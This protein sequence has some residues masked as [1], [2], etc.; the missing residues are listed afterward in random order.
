MTK[1]ID[2]HTHSI[3]SDGSF[4]PGQIAIKAQEK[5]LKGIV[6]TDHNI[7]DGFQEMQ[8]SCRR[9]RLK[10]MSGIE[11]TSLLDD[12]NMHILLYNIE[13]LINDSDFYKILHRLWLYDNLKT[14]AVIKEFDKA[15]LMSTS[16]EEIRSY[17]NLPGPFVHRTKVA[18]YKARI[19]D[20]TYEQVKREAKTLGIWNPKGKSELLAN[21]INLLQLAMKHNAKPVLAHPFNIREIY[22]FED[23]DKA[24]KMLLKL[25]DRLKE[26][27]LVGLEAYHY[28][29][30]TEQVKIIKAIAHEKELFVTGGSDFHGEIHPYCTLGMNGIT[31]D[32]FIKFANINNR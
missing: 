4:Y 24:K 29:H 20:Q 9:L 10:T 26:Y 19:M 2:M 13:S 31:E 6:L 23:L 1:E 18:I 22:K 12:Y 14:E 11:I 17:L 8:M 32:E 15:W 7:F 21:T 3:Y 27:G 5:G 16:L 25:V 30:N 28:V